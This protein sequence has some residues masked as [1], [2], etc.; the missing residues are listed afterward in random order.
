L[1]GETFTRFL[2]VEGLERRI[3]IVV[4]FEIAKAVGFDPLPLMKEIWVQVEGL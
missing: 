2:K 4:F 1:S 3:D